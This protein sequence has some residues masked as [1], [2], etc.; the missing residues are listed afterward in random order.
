MSDADVEWSGLVFDAVDAGLA[1]LDRDGRVH[2]WNNCLASLTRNQPASAV[3][4]SLTDA[5][6]ASVPG[7]LLASINQAVE[8]GASSTLSHA[9][10]PAPLPLPDRLGRPVLHNVTVTPIGELGTYCL[11]AIR[12]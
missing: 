12:N 2:A 8:A 11:L 5:L 1:V 3:G 10:H 7:R 9:L 4:R 6:G